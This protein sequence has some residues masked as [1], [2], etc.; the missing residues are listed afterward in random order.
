MTKSHHLNLKPKI[1]QKLGKQFQYFHT[2]SIFLND[3]KLGKNPVEYIPVFNTIKSNQ[4]K[5]QQKNGHVIVGL[6]SHQLI[7]PHVMI[8]PEDLEHISNT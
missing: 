4:I 8:I 6:R 2:I 1:G 7:I 3:Q 5:I